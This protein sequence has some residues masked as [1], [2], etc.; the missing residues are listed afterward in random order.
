[1]AD[2]P[3]LDRQANAALTMRELVIGHESDRN[4]ADHFVSR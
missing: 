3:A 4:V 2:R 1:V